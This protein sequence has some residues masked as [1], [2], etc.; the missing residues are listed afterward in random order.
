MVFLASIHQV[1]FHFT[2]SRV[3]L[4]ATPKGG[5]YQR[6]ATP[7]NSG[8]QPAE[9]TIYSAISAVNG[10]TALAIAPDLL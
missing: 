8:H 4:K 6:P 7:Q 10:E 1:W 9:H 2:G 3:V 5:K